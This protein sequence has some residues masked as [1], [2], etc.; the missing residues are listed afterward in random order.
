MKT[1]DNSI[2]LSIVVPAYNE[3]DNLPVLCESLFDVLNSID[4]DWELILVDDGSSDNTWNAIKALRE[5][6]QRVRGVRLSRNFGHQRALVAG[7]GYTQGAAVISMDADMQH[8][9]SLIPTLVEEWRVGNKIV[10]TKRLDPEDTPR[11]KKIT[12][13]WFYRIFSFVSGVSLE[14]GM[15]DYRLIDREVLQEILRF[16]EEGAFLRGI[17]EWVGFPSST[18]PYTCA[19]RHSGQTKYTLPKMIKLAWEG[20]SSFSLVPLRIG[21]VIGFLASAFSFIAVIYA[22]VGR[23][24]TGTAVP[25]WASTLAIM[26]FLFGILFS[27]L[28]LLGEY[29]GRVLIEV[30]QRPRFLVSERIGLPD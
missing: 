6:D 5:R 24:I 8:P 11:F 3:A 9:P 15:A 18:V 4:G 21:V 28:G 12:S 16:R 10:K 19:L 30:R 20:V 25:G 7:L 2:L 14:S 27:Y 13:D 17:V 29:L 23:L 1:C 22:I 26:S